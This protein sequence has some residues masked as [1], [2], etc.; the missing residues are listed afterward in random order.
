MF[1][2]GCTC[3]HTSGAAC[4]AGHCARMSA[5][6]LLILVVLLV[7]VSLL[8]LRTARVQRQFAL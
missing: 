6:V 3:E 4:G 2:N 8:I 7:L 1:M 5:F